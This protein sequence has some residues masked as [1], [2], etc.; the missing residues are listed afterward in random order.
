[1]SMEESMPLATEQSVLDSFFFVRIN[2]ALALFSGAG[3]N[4]KL[5]FT[6]LAEETEG[7]LGHP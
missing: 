5:D 4:P 6:E 3:L 7:D 2:G 1:M